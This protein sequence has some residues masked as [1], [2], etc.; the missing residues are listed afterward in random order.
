MKRGSLTYH[1]CPTCGR[2]TPVELAELHCPN[3]GSRLLSACPSCG[4]AITTPYTRYCTHCGE[5]LGS[6][7]EGDS[8]DRGTPPFGEGEP[9]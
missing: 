4:A 1:L 3:D 9:F 8:D 6:R 5:A 7:A 2:A